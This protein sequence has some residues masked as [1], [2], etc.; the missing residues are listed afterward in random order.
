MMSNRGAGLPS[1]RTSG[2]RR[3][4]AAWRTTSGTRLRKSGINQSDPVSVSEK[5]DRFFGAVDSLAL[6]VLVEA[7][8]RLAVG[9]FWSYPPP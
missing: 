8:S 5:S 6:H 4:C 2:G 7:R 1:L 3:S 9:S